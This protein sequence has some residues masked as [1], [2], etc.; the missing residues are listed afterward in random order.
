MVTDTVTKEDFSMLTTTLLLA[1][2]AAVI[3]FVSPPNPV[4]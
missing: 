3:A 4:G 1:A 2:A